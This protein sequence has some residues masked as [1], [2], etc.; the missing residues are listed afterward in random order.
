MDSNAITQDRLLQ[1]FDIDIFEASLDEGQTRANEPDVDLQSEV[2]KD[3]GLHSKYKIQALLKTCIHGIWDTESKTPTSLIVVDYS[4]KNLEEGG[5]FS[6]VTTGFEFEP[7]VEDSIGLGLVSKNPLDTPRVVA[8]APFETAVQWDN[9]TAK[10]DSKHTFDA[11]IEPEV[12]GVKAGKIGYSYEANRSHEQRYF[13]RGLAGR[14]FIQKGPAR[15]IPFCV[16]WN[17]QHNFSQKDGV[18][19]NFRTA[20]LV[21]RRTEAANSKFIARFS[22]AVRGGF[23]MALETLI[24]FFL[25]R[26]IK[27]RP[28]LFDPSIKLMGV[29]LDGIEVNNEGEYE[30]GHLAE[31]T[32][33]VKLSEVW[34]LAP[35]VQT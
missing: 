20:F 14:H 15:N 17:L 11:A 25:R 33:L 3:Q 30:L 10:E 19:P 24:N 2:I 29:K 18:P 5:R 1:G 22:I 26:N 13:S 27:T 9:T 21:T 16:W 28:I 4:L 12:H 31:G 32:E 23:G 8:L 6:S 7:Y 34:G 35:L